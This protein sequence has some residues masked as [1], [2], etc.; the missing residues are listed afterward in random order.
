MLQPKKTKFRKKQK[1]R[2]KGN[3]E[4]GHTLSNGMFGMKSV[5]ET[6]M[7][8]TSRQIEAARSVG[9]QLQE[10]DYLKKYTGVYE[11]LELDED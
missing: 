2:M 9:R 5:H 6:G 8:L 3:S 4:R 7:F 10:I 1:G 11:A